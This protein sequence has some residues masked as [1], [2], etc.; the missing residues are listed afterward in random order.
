M[1]K[2]KIC[3]KL[4]IENLKRCL[5]WNKKVKFGTIFKL[6]R[7]EYVVDAVE[8]ICLVGINVFFSIFVLKCLITFELIYRLTGGRMCSGLTLMYGQWKTRKIKY[9]GCCLVCVNS[10][11]IENRIRCIPSFIHINLHH[12]QNFPKRMENLHL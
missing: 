2:L 5:F 8:I 12:C 10:T 3:Y 11:Y 6:K 9:S 7:K 4:C 1:I